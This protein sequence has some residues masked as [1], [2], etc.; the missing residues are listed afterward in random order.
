MHKTP[1]LAAQFKTAGKAQFE[2]DVRA[3]LEVL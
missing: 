2:A 1:E 3:L